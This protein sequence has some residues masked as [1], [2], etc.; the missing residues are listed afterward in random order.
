MFGSDVTT[1]VISNEEKNMM[2]KFKS[3]KEYGLL[4]KDVSEIVKNKA[5]EHKD[6]FSRCYY[7]L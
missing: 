2:K 6:D 3:L 5:K 1:L 7:T 4:I